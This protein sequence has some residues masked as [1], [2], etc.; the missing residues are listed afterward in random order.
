MTD[1]GLKVK[2]KDSDS[3]LKAKEKDYFIIYIKHT[4]LT[5]SKV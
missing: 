1:S 2:Y 5:K 3:Q 4:T